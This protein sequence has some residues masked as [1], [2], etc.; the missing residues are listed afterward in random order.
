MSVR[1]YADIGAMVMVFTESSLRFTRYL[2]TEKPT[3]VM[4]KEDN[5]DKESKEP[6]YDEDKRSARG[7]A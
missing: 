7:K 6:D 3:T 4:A 2:Q 5:N 1:S